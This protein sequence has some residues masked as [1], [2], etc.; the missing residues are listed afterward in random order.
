MAQTTIDSCKR[1][2]WVAT[3][4]VEGGCRENP[5]VWGIGG[6]A[7]SLRQH[8]KRCGQGRRRIVGD[9]DRPSRN[10]RWQFDDVE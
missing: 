1:H 8:C 9:V 4:S 5:G 7:I 2:S 10:T 3:M 6:A